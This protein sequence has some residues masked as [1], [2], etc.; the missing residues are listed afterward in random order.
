MTL[1]WKQWEGQVVDGRFPLLRYLGGGERS[2]VFETATDDPTLPK[3]AI[4]LV[5]PDPDEAETQLVRWESAAALEH[6]HLLRLFQIGR[7]QLD[8]VELIYVVM[9]YADEALSQVV[10][11]RPLSPAEALDILGPTLDALT[12]VHAQGFVHGRV[13]PSNLL[14]VG[15]RLKLSSDR[16]CRTG[17]ARRNSDPLDVYDAPETAAGGLTP[18]ADVWSLGVTLTEALTQ[19]SQAVPPEGLSA[20]LA[21]VVRGCLERD[22]NR[23]WTL[24]QIQASLR[25][26]AAQPPPAAAQ[27]SDKRWRT[28][29]LV[30]AMVVAAAI[31]AG[32]RLARR[33]AA[34]AQP[35]SALPQAVE[36]ATPEAAIQTPK[37][38]APA[39]T[40]EATQPVAAMTPPA[41]A[42]TGEVQHR[43][44]PEVLSRA[45][46]SI[47]GRVRVKVKI[48]VN[49][50]GAVTHAELESRGPSRYFA[51][52]ALEAS[53]QWTFTPAG[54]T[55][56]LL[57]WE[58]ERSG[59]KVRPEPL[60]R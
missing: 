4:K 57:H 34:P 2:A 25:P 24:A 36:T 55:Q 19:R 21:P 48:R 1:N 29:A 56:W 17:P 22:A 6:P 15:D 43:V 59:T 28:A 7:C 20:P 39:P 51:E 60:R 37:P 26:A 46:H 40:P 10:L 52:R 5:R 49:E 12:Y 31:V 42:A 32:P 16:L 30:A 38:V 23:R 9:E 50:A 11:Q 45:Q 14:A 35:S 58:F 27:P 18:A 3:A 8:D 47:R 53:R 33:R 41:P 54:P 44:M 13:R